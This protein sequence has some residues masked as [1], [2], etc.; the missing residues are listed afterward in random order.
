ME[1]QAFKDAL[2]GWATGVSVVASRCDGLVYGITVSSFTS[3]SLSP[4]L[5]LV[6]IHNASRINEMVA[7]S[8]RFTVS[9]LNTEQGDVSTA[10]AT[11]GREPA[12]T[13]TECEQGTTEMGLPC[14]GGAL[15]V[16]GCGLH[17]AVVLGDHTILV[18]EVH[19]A[20]NT[21]G[22]PILYFRRGYR[23]LDLS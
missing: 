1:S 15:A 10:F 17:K 9:I 4:P 11:P 21:E 18:G 16:L 20:S 2:S 12:Q 14:V 19:E 8:G 7:K 22:D 23:T 3:V 6:C 13:F 5:I